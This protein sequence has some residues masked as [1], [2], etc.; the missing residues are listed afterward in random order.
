V[1]NLTDSVACAHMYGPFI[2]TAHNAQACIEAGNKGDQVARKVMWGI[3]EWL[4]SVYVK[5]ETV[6]I[7]RDCP[8]AQSPFSKTNQ[9]A[10]FLV[11]LP[12]G[13]K[14]NFGLV[15]AACKHCLQQHADD[16]PN[17]I[18]QALQ[19]QYSSFTVQSHTL[20]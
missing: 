13:D 10:A 17:E 15:M 4:S 5:E 12:L 16:L 18:M 20:H 9:P 11:M 3:N 7:C 14:D 2:I 8:I 6:C 19:H 1:I